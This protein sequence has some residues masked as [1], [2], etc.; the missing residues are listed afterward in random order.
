[1]GYVFQCFSQA[2]RDR[3]A[4]LFEYEEDR[5]ACAEPKMLDAMVGRGKLTIQ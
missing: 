1:M 4:I 3:A 2:K 5:A